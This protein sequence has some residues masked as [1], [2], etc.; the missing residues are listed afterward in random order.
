MQQET[1][2]RLDTDM[3]RLQHNHV[4][5]LKDKYQGLIYLHLSESKPSFSIYVS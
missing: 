1:E 5:L 2:A 4:V 3:A